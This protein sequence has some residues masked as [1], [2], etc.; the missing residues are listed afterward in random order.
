MQ[1][2]NVRDYFNNLKEKYGQE[3]YNRLIWKMA[4]CLNIKKDGKFG[5]IVDQNLLDKI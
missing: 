4:G 1:D 3:W 2:F 5:F